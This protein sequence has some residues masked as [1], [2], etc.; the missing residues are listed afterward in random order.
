METQDQFPVEEIPLE[1]RMEY[2]GLDHFRRIKPM[3]LRSYMVKHDV[4]VKHFEYLHHF[5]F[6]HHASDEVLLV[7]IPTLCRVK[8]WLDDNECEAID[9]CTVDSEDT[10]PHGY[11]SWL[12]ALGVT[13]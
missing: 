7:P 13:K 11:P 3:L 1:Y 10:C 12:I 8:Q 5:E 9:G 6:Y 4:M 2:M